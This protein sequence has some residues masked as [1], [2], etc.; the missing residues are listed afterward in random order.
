MSVLIE[1]LTLVARRINVEMAH[2]GGA[3][4][5][6][7]LAAARDDVRYAIADDQ[8]IAVSSFEPVAIQY[9][10]EVL[11]EANLLFSNGD[12][13]AEAVVVDM[14]LGP[15][16]SSPWLTV[17]RH[18]HCFTTA[19]LAAEQSHRLVAPPSWTPAQGW[20]LVREDLRDDGERNVRSLGGENGREYLLDY[21]TGLVHAGFET[22]SPV[23]HVEP[24]TDPT[25]VPMARSAEVVAAA[26]RL[27]TRIGIP[28]IVDVEHRCVVVPFALDDVDDENRDDVT[29]DDR[30]RVMLRASSTPESVT[31]VVVLPFFLHEKKNAV[32]WAGSVEMMETGWPAIEFVAE[33]DEDTGTMALV[34]SV[35][36]QDG[37]C[38]EDVVER[39][40][41][42]ASGLGTRG[43]VWTRQ[44]TLRE[45][46]SRKGDLYW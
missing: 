27:L 29:P 23:H 12:A 8:L 24:D 4:D 30:L 16:E 14:E 3:D 5:F 28:F 45:R 33:V 41:T 1:A 21:R 35:A 19:T 46:S 11:G 9:L 40:L 17:S 26:F 18:A 36:R 44:T 42:R 37:Q 7:R 15:L 34:T 38:V 32:R 10:S 43:V 39:A 2:S 25:V 6:L 22:R 20:R 13:S 31:A